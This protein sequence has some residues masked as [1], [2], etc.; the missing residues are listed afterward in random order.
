MSDNTNTDENV[1]N[2]KTTHNPPRLRRAIL[3]PIK[4]EEES[5]PYVLSNKASM[6]HCITP[7]KA[8]DSKEEK[9]QS[10][11]VKALKKLFGF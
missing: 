4:E 8:A 11:A 10:K 9:K 7:T 6:L 5:S 3:V 2:I 1:L